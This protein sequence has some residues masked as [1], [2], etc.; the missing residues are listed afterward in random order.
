MKTFAVLRKTDGVKVYE[1]QDEAP[2]EWIDFPF[3]QFDHVEQPEAPVVE[4]DPVPAERWKI[5]VGAFFD[6][7]GAAKLAVLASNDAHVQAAIKDASV[8]KYID[9]LGR[10][11]ELE[12]LIGY[13]QSKGH[14]IEV[15]AIL[16]VVPTDDE[17]WHE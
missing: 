11:E 7:F 14:A 9:L 17:V 5:W 4:P 6:R 2:V 16:D 13:I 1:Y 8:R 10:R 3:S 15:E 12:Q